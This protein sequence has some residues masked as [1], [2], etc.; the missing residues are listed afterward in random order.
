MKTTSKSLVVVALLLSFTLLAGCGPHR[1]YKERGWG[2]PRFS[3]RDFPERMLK[4]MD[5]K[6][7]EL[8][9]TEGQRETYG[10]IRARIKANVVKAGEE[11]ED[12]FTQLREGLDRENPDMNALVGMVKGK[13][14]DMPEHMGQAL[15]LFLEFFNV[16]DEDQKANVVEM[17]REKAERHR[18]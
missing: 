5:N 15:D 18:D 6:V 12:L 9:L 16:L 2:H 14:K 1:Y 8:D 13:L 10:E 7:E 4:R 17:I 3:S 11:R